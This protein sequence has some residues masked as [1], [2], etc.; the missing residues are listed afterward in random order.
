MVDIEESGLKERQMMNGTKRLPNTQDDDLECASLVLKAM[1]HPLRLKILCVMRDQEIG[2]QEIVDNVGSSHSNI[3][4]H[5]GLLRDRGI[6]SYRRDAQHSFYRIHNTHTLR[7][8]TMT[9]ELFC[10][11]N[12]DSPIEQG[13]EK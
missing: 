10:Q 8:I 9:R 13:M 6:L 5:L 2:L 11:A 3:V 12:G 7:L 4:Q 1:S